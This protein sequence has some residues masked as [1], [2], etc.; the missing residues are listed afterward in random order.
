[1]K[2][3]AFFAIVLCL[4]PGQAFAGAWTLPEG[5]TQIITTVTQSDASKSYDQNSRPTEDVTYHKIF[6]TAYSEY[7]WNDWLTLIATPEY[8]S[9]SSATPGLA[10]QKANDFAISGG[11][12]VRLLNDDDNVVSLQATARSA[13]A[14][15]LD[16][17]YDQD[18]GEDFELRALYGR[19]FELFG[20]PGCF[21]VQ[22]AQRWA[23]GKRP[24]E[25]PVDVSLLYDVGWKTQ[26]MLQSFNVISEGSGEPPFGY[27][28][29]HKIALSAVRPLWGKFSTQIGFFMTPAGQNALREQGLFTG[30]WVKF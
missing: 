24:D 1:M 19:N 28:R 9:A 16:T 26:V 4:V 29:Y 2:P 30:I 17:S 13:G 22:V 25:M 3:A 8:A 10:T 15:E 23:T 14:F 18:P 27:Y 12:R 7:G 11:A 21:D 20:H 5:T 6:L